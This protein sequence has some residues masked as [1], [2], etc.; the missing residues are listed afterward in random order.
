M[1][2]GLCYLWYGL[3]NSANTSDPTRS[4]FLYLLYTSSHI[5]FQTIVSVYPKCPPYILRSSHFY[6]ST[7]LTFRPYILHFLYL[8]HAR[9]TDIPTCHPPLL[10]SLHLPHPHH[11]PNTRGT[12]RHSMQRKDLVRQGT[13][14]MPRSGATHLFRETGFG[15]TKELLLYTRRS[16]LVFWPSLAGR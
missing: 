13:S 12:D 15:P 4:V 16:T 5:R 7:L 8:L 3:H 10:T 1:L 6:F 2:C 11:Q 9:Q 14:I